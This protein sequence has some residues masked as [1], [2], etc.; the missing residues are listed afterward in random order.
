MAEEG[1][2]RTGLGDGVSEGVVGVLRDCI[3]VLIQIT[4]DVAYVV[5]ARNVKL[6]SGGVGSGGVGDGEVEES[7][8]A[9]SAL[10]R[11]RQIFAPVIVNCGGCA[12]RVGD[13]FLNEIPAI[14][15]EGCA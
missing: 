10:K 12:V 8:D 14:V 7:A 5:V 2:K 1:G 4:Y 15:E 11:S 13:A 3:A 6:L 9:A